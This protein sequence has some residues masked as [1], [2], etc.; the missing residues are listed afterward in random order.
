MTRWV[1]VAGTVGC[2]AFAVVVGTAYVLV[3]AARV[4][5][6]RCTGTWDPSEE[7]LVDEPP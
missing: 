2:V 3:A 5:E 1:V 6:R 4:V 7:V